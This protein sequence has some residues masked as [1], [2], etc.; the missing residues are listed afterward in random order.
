MNEHVRVGT[1]IKTDEH[2]AHCWLGKTT[3]K[4]TFQPCRPALYIHKKCNHSV[5]FKAHD[6]T[7]THEIEG[8]NNMIKHPYKA[9]SGLPKHVLPQFLDQLMFEGWT[10][11]VLPFS[12]TSHSKAEKDKMFNNFL[13]LLVGLG[14]LCC[15]NNQEWC[16][17][18]DFLAIGGKLELK[19]DLCLFY[20]DQGHAKDENDVPHDDVFELDLDCNEYDFDF[21]CDNSDDSDYEE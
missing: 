2:K 16:Y 7:H 1:T 11:S 21:E 15:Q 4:R 19:D 14:E 18:H 10:N 5:G 3:S 6:G 20:K 13:M 8:K 17:E 9:M 12:E